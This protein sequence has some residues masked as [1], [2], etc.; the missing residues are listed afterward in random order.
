VLFTSARF[1]DLAYEALKV[2]LHSFS[3]MK[4]GEKPHPMLVEDFKQSTRAVLFG[5]NSFWQG[6]DIPGRALESVIITKLPFAVPD[7]PLTESRIEQLKAQEL[8]PFVHF[9]LPQAIIWLKQGFGR[10]IRSRDDRGMVA[11]LDSRIKNRAYGRK[12]IRS[13]PPCRETSSLKE[14]ETFFRALSERKE[15]G[16]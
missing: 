13:L 14:V 5:T 4:Q 2:P 11:L 12:F 3:L 6:I 15:P 16:K 10:L 7:D 8:D 1:M 9:Q